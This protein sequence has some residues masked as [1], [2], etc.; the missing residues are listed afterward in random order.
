M[1]ATATA[2]VPGPVPPD[3]TATHG[4]GLCVVQTHPA[5][6]LTLTATAAPVDDTVWFVGDAEKLQTGG[7]GGGG[8]V[9]AAA[10]L[11]LSVRPATVT[12][13]F[14]AAPPLGSTRKTTSPGPIAVVDPDRR[15]HST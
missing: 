11:T 14:R 9:G 1:A 4:T 15:I 7:G 3:V 6:V 10:W 5:V 2:A 13:P 8:A 12:V